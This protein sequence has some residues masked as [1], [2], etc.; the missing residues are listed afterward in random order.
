MHFPA[1][2]SRRAITI[3][4]L[5]DSTTGLAPKSC[6]ARIDASITNSKR[7]ETLSKQSSTVILA[8]LQYSGFG[9]L[10]HKDISTVPRLNYLKSF[11]VH[12]C[13]RVAHQEMV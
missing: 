6:F 1:A 4:R 12:G 7:L 13:G 10:E 9:I 5:S 2:I 8:I 3:S 11:V